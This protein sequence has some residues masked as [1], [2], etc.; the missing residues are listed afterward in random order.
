MENSKQSLLAKIETLKLTD[1]EQRLLDHWIEE[2][3]GDP[4]LTVD[5]DLDDDPELE[6]IP[7]SHDPTLSKYE[8]KDMEKI[9]DLGPLKHD[10]GMMF[11]TF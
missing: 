3:E 4:G 8:L 5:F 9:V 7:I 2:A 1:D 6:E 10:K 11:R